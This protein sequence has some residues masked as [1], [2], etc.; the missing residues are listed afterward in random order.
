MNSGDFFPLNT[1]PSLAPGYLFIGTRL[2][3]HSV[4][5]VRARGARLLCFPATILGEIRKP[6]L[7]M[8]LTGQMGPLIFVSLCICSIGFALLFQLQASSHQVTLMRVRNNPSQMRQ[9]PRCYV[10]CR[11]IKHVGLN[12]GTVERLWQRKSGL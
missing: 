3:S 12:L 4:G 11:G 2:W 5:F 7:I 9:I 8:I 6:R 10:L 1:T